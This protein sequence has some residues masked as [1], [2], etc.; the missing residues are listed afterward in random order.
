MNQ[1]N[2]IILNELEFAKKRLAGDYDS[3]VPIMQTLSILSR[4]YYHVEGFR[5]KKIAELLMEYL[6]K[7]GLIGFGEK[8]MW[9]DIT[10][11]FGANAKKHDL[12][13]LDGVNITRSELDKI[14]TLK[15]KTLQR[16]AFTMLCLAKYANARN[17]NN[18][19][20]V[21]DDAKDIFRMARISC[22]A[23][24]RDVKIG[25]LH[26]LGFLNFAK[27]ITNLSCQVTYI[28][29]GSDTVLFISDFRELGYEYLKYCGENFVRCAE[30]DILIRGNKNNTRVYCDNCV[31]PMVTK[32][33]KCID[34][35]EMF[36]VSAKNNKSRRCPFCYDLYRREYYRLN[37]KK[38]RMSTEQKKMR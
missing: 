33:V 36:E 26:N 32:K 4:Y 16:L 21:R 13:K 20:W 2:K 9:E 22:S 7:N 19:N 38:N 37:K 6:R 12:L 25:Q 24:E 18:N 30:C 17:A 28:D 8:L 31:A 11:R 10:D 23:H 29:D 15:S 34:C 14:A 5:R 27:K 3:S 1:K 35:G